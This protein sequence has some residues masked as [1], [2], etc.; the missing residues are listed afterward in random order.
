MVRF[1]NKDISQSVLNGKKVICYGDSITWGQ[2]GYEPSISHCNWPD[3]LSEMTGADVVNAGIPASSLAYV[4]DDENSDLNRDSFVHRIQNADLTGYDYVF[5][6]YGT[7]DLSYGV[8]IGT[9]G[10]PNPWTFKG[11]YNT[12]LT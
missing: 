7:N 10:D 1:M 11:G 6:A 2:A 8:P 4:S 12:A 5:I 9:N 3:V